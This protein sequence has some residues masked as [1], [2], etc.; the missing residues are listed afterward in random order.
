MQSSRTELC[1]TGATVTALA[2]TRHRRQLEA[3]ASCGS[4]SR[5]SG[6]LFQCW[7]GLR[8]SGA[9]LG[10]SLPPTLWPVLQT[11]SEVGTSLLSCSPQPPDFTTGYL[12][13]QR[14]ETVRV[15]YIEQEPA[16]TP[17]LTPEC[18]TTVAGLQD[19]LPL[20]PHHWD[21][22]TISPQSSKSLGGESTALL[23][24]PMSTGIILADL[25]GCINPTAP[26]DLLSIAS[27]VPVPSHNVA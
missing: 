7:P 8:S 3:H 10:P 16:L 13:E 5:G 22:H 11:Q 27:Q 9:I 23:I 26:S 6:T 4:L 14:H 20:S 2:P 21:H 18:L 25:T 19:F 24:Y 1:I 15:Q 17:A 12:I